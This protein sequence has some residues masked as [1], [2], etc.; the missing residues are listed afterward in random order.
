MLDIALRDLSKSFPG[1]LAVD[2]VS[3]DFRPGEIHALLGENGAGKSTLMHLVS[4]LYRPDSGTI[5]IDGQTHS[6][7]SA[8]DA[9][10]AG[11]AMVH[12]HFML[13]P[14][15]T[16]AENILLAQPGRR[17]SRID[18]P[19]LAQHVIELAAHYGI[20][21][22]N[23]D[24]PVSALSVGSQQ[25]VEILKALAVQARVLILDEPTAVL[26]PTEVAN[27]FGVLRRLKH[28][29]YTILLITHKIP[30]VLAI[31]DRLSVL[32][33]GR[34]IA[35]KDIARC[36]PHELA[37]LMVGQQAELNS[38][39]A[40]PTT[41]NHTSASV[42]PPL[43]QVT[44]AAT[45]TL[46]GGMPLQQISFALSTG[47]IVGIA[48][49][50]GNGQTELLEMLLGLRQLT[51]GAIVIDGIA[52][53]Q[54][55]PTHMRAL[56]VA[57][58]PQDRHR[59]GLA[60]P[61]SVEENLLLNSQRLASLTPNTFL[62]PSRVRHFAQQQI[63]TFGIRTASPAEPVSSLSGGNQQRVIIA[64]EL[65]TNPKIILAANPTRGLDIGATAYVHR[66]LIEHC[67]R[68]AGVLFLS[69]DLDEILTLSHRIYALYQGRLLGPVDPTTGRQIVGQMMTGVATTS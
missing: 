28:E 60:L 67:Q 56:G 12:Q 50:D 15:F 38:P 36:T 14:S 58:I 42:Q 3:I 26:T 57:L 33:R 62:T 53:R 20:A 44:A 6:F 10:S 46:N 41:Q 59:E 52:V 54:P 32:R 24:T 13:I 27:L 17:L 65:A 9:L 55:T 35:T 68:G 43:L 64:R 22:E 29:G 63:A 30:E 21:L 25:R 31:A 66:T 37:Q 45:T 4:G 1:V 11:I 34:L 18:R 49:V 7:S 8:R 5:V 2:R 69:T 48:G 47:E 19:A 23:P 40:T 51:H 39:L 61:F 16:I